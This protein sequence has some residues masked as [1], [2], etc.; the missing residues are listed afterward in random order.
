VTKLLLT[1]F[2]LITYT[3]GFSQTPLVLDWAHLSLG[4][5]YTQVSGIAVD[6]V[7]NIY[8]CGALKNEGQMDFTKPVIESS[9]TFSYISKI[10][11]AGEFVWG[12]AFIGSNFGQINFK[13]IKISASGDI[14]CVGDFHGTV[15]F[16]PSENNYELIST[17][18]TSTFVLKLSKNGDF[19][20]CKV[21]QSLNSSVYGNSTAFSFDIDLQDKIYVSGKFSG[22]VDLNPGPDS[23]IYTTYYALQTYGFLVKLDMNGDFVWAN[24]LENGINNESELFALAVDNNNDVIVSGYFYNTISITSIYLD[25]TFSPVLWPTNNQLILKYDQ[26]GQCKC[27][28]V[29]HI[30]GVNCYM[31]EVLCNSTNDIFIL[32]NFTNGISF[33]PSTIDDFFKTYPGSYLNTSDGF[34]AKY[35]ESGHF[36]WA[37][38]FGGIGSDGNPVATFDDA[39]NI[40]V[41]AF[42]N[43]VLADSIYYDSIFLGDSFSDRL[44]FEVNTNGELVRSVKMDGGNLRFNDIEIDKNH[45]LIM[46]GFCNNQEEYPVDF[47]PNPNLSYFIPKYGSGAYVLKFGY[48]LK[49]H[50]SSKG[51]IFPNPSAKELTIHVGTTTDSAKAQFFDFS[52]RMVKEINLTQENTIVDVSS[53]AAG[54]HVVR[55]FLNNETIQEKFLKY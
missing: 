10:T 7:N 15:D 19:I 46:A 12:K 33:S 11:S 32:G 5:G 13:K 2:F 24:V 29:K 26:N 55:L 34:I 27:K 45:N 47:D 6:A 9:E 53:L 31:N 23:M 20:W 50:T 37:N 35:N 16:D 30:I 41:G 18:G 39:E 14:L 17:N 38:N 42:V 44:I 22:K 25:T 54:M 8:Q 3:I 52:G 51:L 21:F 40:L 4:G 49:P 48:S 43:G 28:W 36:Q 1:S